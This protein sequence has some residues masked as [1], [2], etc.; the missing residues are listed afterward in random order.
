MNA[1][2][3]ERGSL[4]EARKV[5]LWF[6]AGA[7]ARLSELANAA[8]TTRSAL[9][10]WLIEHAPVDVDGRPV[11]WERDHPREEELPIDTP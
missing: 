7:D 6:E 4:V 11:G 2:R 5:G 1:R 8:G 9:A 10:Q 3:R